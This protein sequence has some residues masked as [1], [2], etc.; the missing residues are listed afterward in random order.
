M[1]SFWKEGG[2]YSLSG[3]KGAIV[4]Y[5]RREYWILSPVGKG[6]HQEAGERWSLYGR[7][8]K[9]VSLFQEEGGGV[10]SRRKG[11]DLPFVG[12]RGGWL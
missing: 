6:T 2:R 5:G 8:G 1:F 3:R 4:L 12:G 9:V 11:D 7:K 10:S